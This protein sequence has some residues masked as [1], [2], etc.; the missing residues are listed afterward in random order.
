V[1]PS[2]IA[3]YR[4]VSKLGAGGMGE[5]YL[6]EDQKLGRPVA[7]KLLPV[8]FTA[9]LE[10]VRRFEQEARAVGALNHPNILTIYEIG[11]ADTS[12]GPVQFMAIEYVEG[13]TLQ[14]RLF[15]RPMT[16]EEAVDVA[17]QICSALAA[18]HGAGIT[19]RDIKPENV[20]LRQD[21]L[22]KVLDF[23]LAKLAE[24]QFLATDD[25][26][27]HAE[28]IDIP[29]LSSDPGPAVRRPTVP[30]AILG[31]VR[32][33]SPEQARGFV[34]DPRS[35]LF[36]LG[37]VLYEMIAGRTPF[38]RAT[39]TDTIVAILEHEAPPLSRYAPAAPADLS[40]LIARLLAKDR[41]ARYQ[42]ARNLLGD[43]KGVQQ[44]L[45][46]AKETEG[47]VQAAEAVERAH[48][49]ERVARRE[50]SQTASSS[51]RGIESLAVLPFVTLSQDPN[52][53]Y[54]AEGI[55]ES[56][57][58]NLSRLSQ[59]RVMAWSTVARFRGLEPDPLETGR[60]LGVR[61]V[62]TARM[63]RLADT[64]VIRAELVD[65]IDGS[66]IWGEQF[67]RKL[68]DLF[69]IDQEISQEICEHLRV[70]LNEDERE[71]LARRYTENA[72]AYQS[73]LKGRYYWNQRSAR[74][75]RKAVE[76]FDEAIRYDS[77]YAMAYAGLADSYCLMSI[78]GAASPK[79]VMPRARTAATK[80]LEI[81]EGLAE[82]HTSMALAL[83]WFDW[84][85][86]GSEREFARAIELSP[87]YAVAHHFHGSVLLTIQQRFDEAL[88]AE[89]R[90]L[91]L[92]PLSLIIN[93]SVGFICYQAHRYEEAIDAL[94]KTLEMDDT[95]TYAR[96]NLAM[97][98]AQLGRYDQAIAELRRALEMA[99]GRGALFYAALGYACGV[100]GRKADADQMLESLRTSGRETSSFYEAMV[101]V[102][103]GRYSEAI[104]ALTTAVDDRF[105]W[106][107]WLQTEPMFTPLHEDP[108]FV[109]LTE[110][111]GLPKTASPETP[112]AR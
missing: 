6:A 1:I 17:I 44:R 56:L 103:S 72:S 77:Q 49:P 34:A 19:H 95:F 53:V 107:V 87:A 65:V 13:Q 3:H 89:R 41:S 9:N 70:K 12:E 78:Y 83:A 73:Y 42:S 81:D 63:H 8:R 99:G 52:A 27:T 100:A 26:A 24:R 66:Q 57:I 4:I 46:V 69:T 21:G 10:R 2:A 85:W 88:A 111:I 74:S 37:V 55:P 20:M 31:T 101:H 68:D 76:S 112:S 29:P 84:D 97:S 22:V 25:L 28:S 38:E 80:A 48:S 54:L 45:W 102:G 15:D 96:Y 23:G 93:S 40:G 33:M 7:L 60:A 30:G 92:E 82:A 109:E 94:A 43:L 106:V 16:V 47:V 108:R 58:R 75:L 67:R 39:S 79:I 18:A 105:N 59:L 62:F 14:Q 86:A 64:L 91:D 36:S 90:A 11:H 32:Y 61:A 98:C 71:R 104:G 5:V 51:R 110:R 35:D 50:P